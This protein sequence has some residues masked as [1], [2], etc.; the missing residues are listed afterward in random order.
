MSVRICQSGTNSHPLLVLPLP[1]DVTAAAFGGTENM[2]NYPIHL[3][4]QTCRLRQAIISADISL[5]LNSDTDHTRDVIEFRYR[6]P[7]QIISA[8]IT[9]QDHSDTATGL[10]VDFLLCS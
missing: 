4:K 5:L 10:S 3:Y 9:L 6:I 7:I 2:L 8:D 1:R